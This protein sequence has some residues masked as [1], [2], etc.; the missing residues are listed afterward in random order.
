MKCE[1]LN[2]SILTWEHIKPQYEEKDFSEANLL[3]KLYA[4]L[5]HEQKHA[6]RLESKY[7]RSIDNKPYNYRNMA[8]EV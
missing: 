8:G 5:E 7:Y 4:A 6:E 1:W 3:D 2:R